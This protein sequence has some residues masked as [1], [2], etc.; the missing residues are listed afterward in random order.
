[1]S[2]VGIKSGRFDHPFRLKL[3]GIWTLIEAVESKK[4]IFLTGAFDGMIGNHG[5]RGHLSSG[6]DT[7]SS[8]LL[9]AVHHA[10]DRSLHVRNRHT[11]VVII[12]P[13]R[14]IIVLPLSMYC[15][16]SQGSWSAGGDEFPVSASSA[17]GGNGPPHSLTAPNT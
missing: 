12:F 13:M 2:G 7:N 1:M 16:S 5:I 6:C 4:L 3:V 14:F 11:I 8:N 15:S 10:T 9:Q 17:R